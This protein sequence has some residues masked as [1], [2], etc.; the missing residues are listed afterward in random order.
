MAAALAT[1]AADPGEIFQIIER[2]GE[3]CVFYDV[4]RPAGK[5][6]GVGGSGDG[7]TPLLCSPHPS[8]LG[9]VQFIWRSV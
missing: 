5:R 7:L 3:G 4:G 9:Q 2:L 1:S 8:C 6:E